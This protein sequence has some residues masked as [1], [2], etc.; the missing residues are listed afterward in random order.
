[1][2]PIT[3]ISLVSNVISFI[4]FGTTVIRGA[5]RVQDA[6]ALEDNDTLDSV[7]RQMQ[8]FTVKLL[9]PAQTNLTGTDL[10]LAEL[11]AKCRDVAGDLLELQQAIWSVIKNMKYDEEKKSLKALAA[12][13]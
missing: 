5:K 9:A 7:A 13:N 3:A 1:M 8:T 4:D 12:V 11:A 10:G 2:D 6:G